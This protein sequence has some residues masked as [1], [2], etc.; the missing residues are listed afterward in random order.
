MPQTT[1]IVDR[2]AAAIARGQAGERVH[3]HFRHAG[4]AGGEHHPLGLARRRRNVRLP[5]LSRRMRR[6]PEDR[7]RRS[8]P[9]RIDHDRVDIR[10]GDDRREVIGF[11]IGRQDGEAARD[12]VE[13]DQASAV[14]NWPPVASENGFAGQRRADRRALVPRP[15]PRSGRSRYIEKKSLRRSDALPQ[16]LRLSARHFRRLSRNRRASPGKSASSEAVNGSTPSRIFKPRDQ[17]GKAERVEAAIPTSTRSSLQRR[18]NFAMFAAPTSSICSS[19]VN[20]IDIIADAT[21]SLFI[22]RRYIPATITI[23]FTYGTWSTRMVSALPAFRR[24]QIDESDLP[25]LTELLRRGFPNRNRQ[26]WH[27]AFTS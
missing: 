21:Y 15:D 9:N 4:R 8:R 20:F 17:D 16:R 6:G 11:G 22:S 27:R 7:K 14:V 25:A 3:D 18:Q 13:F 1:A 2:P 10:S 24:R 12:A 23:K 26:F 5:R 19:M